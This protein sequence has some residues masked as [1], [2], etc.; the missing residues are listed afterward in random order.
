MDINPTR[1]SPANFAELLDLYMTEQ[2][3]LSTLLATVSKVDDLLEGSKRFILMACSTG[4]IDQARQAEQFIWQVADYTSFPEHRV[5]AHW[6][7]AIFYSNR[8]VKASLAHT[9]I[10]L[11]YY[12]HT[13]QQTKEAR[14]LIGYASQ[15]NLIGRAEE[16]EA[17]LQRSI[18]HLLPDYGDWPQVYINLSHVYANQ[19]RYTDMLAAARYAE[20]LA[21]AL[22]VNQPAETEK[23]DWF[24]V[25]ALINQGYAALYL[26]QL[27][28]A[29]ET[30]LRAEQLTCRYEWVDEAGHIAVVLSGLFIVKGQL[31]A[32]LRMLQKAHIH[33]KTAQISL[34]EATIALEEA[35]LYERLM[36]KRQ[37]LQMAEWAMQQFANTD[38]AMA[39]AGLLAARLALELAIPSR[40]RRYLS[41][42]ATLLEGAPLFQK[43]LWRGYHAYVGLLEPK[44]EQWRQAFREAESAY[45]DLIGTGAIFEGLEIGLVIARLA[46]AL[47]LPD[48][49]Q[50]L[51]ALVDQARQYGIGAVEQQAL[52]LIA[53]YQPAPDAIQSL[54]RAAD[55]LV[56]LRKGMP[57]EELK[58]HL[59]FGH[60]SLYT[61]L[62]ETQLKCHEKLAA[63][64]TLLEAKG[65]IWVDLSLPTV[66][67]E[68]KPELHCART[69]LNY[70]QHQLQAQ[71]DS[72]VI[73]Y[74]QQRIHKA[75]RLV[76][77]NA[78][79]QVRLRVHRP[80]PTPTEI[81]NRLT[82]DTT[83]LEYLVGETSI[84]CCIISRQSPPCWKRLGKRKKIETL[85]LALQARL[86]DLQVAHGVQE[87]LQLAHDR[88]S[89]VEQTLQQ[90][91]TH[92]IAPLKE[93][94]HST[95]R[96]VIVPDGYLAELPFAALYDGNT[97]LSDCYIISFAPTAA[98]FAMPVSPMTQANGF[99]SQ[100]AIGLGC[101]GHPPLQSIEPEL[102]TFQRCFPN[103]IIKQ[104]ASVSD[105]IWDAP[106]EVLHIASHARIDQQSPL[107]SQLELADGVFLLADVFNL[108]LHGT[109]L[110]TLSACE[111]GVA[112]KQGGMALALSGATLCAGAREVLA[113]LWAVDD[114]ATQLLMADFYQQ[115]CSGQTAAIALQQA[116]K[117]VRQMYQ[118]PFFWAAFQLFGRAL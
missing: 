87:R 114:Q 93:F 103:A 62:I 18:Q 31:L 113:S 21:E 34:E 110:V 54:R 3:R 27:S 4:A 25:S 92:L 73:A 30:L 2:F 96:L 70:W 74:C 94:L 117:H 55:I 24:R 13:R 105:F 5:L 29:E 51:R 26:A 72:E 43:A 66:Q 53:R 116:Q 89:E 28:L 16:A 106:P 22:G 107:L 7:S 44:V 80:M 108:N 42:T 36:M 78:R 97:F 52:I 100:R 68:A 77:Q 63:F 104:P 115:L 56:E 37:A 79:L 102:N 17:A 88:R 1:T 10:A 46:D 9:E 47:E 101:A 69:E 67:N 11:A 82:K 59:L 33:F 109:Q 84:W 12:R 71:K 111:S 85:A 14:I 83:L 90:L 20:E 76:E 57:A 15:L 112:P 61:Y 48:T 81:Q 75:R 40:A 49:L 39:K 23:Y 45:T 118:H 41:E 50:R 95:T 60:A 99:A 64:T 58:A 65:G 8:E 91:Y 35:L 98:L 6:C 86:M 38:I 19:G 32:A